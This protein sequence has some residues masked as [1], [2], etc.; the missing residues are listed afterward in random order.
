[1]QV[2]LTV[3]DCFNDAF[4]GRQADSLAARGLDDIE[5]SFNNVEQDT[6]APT[7]WQVWFSC[8]LDN[9]MPSNPEADNTAAI[10]NPLLRDPS[11]LYEINLRLTDDRE[12]QSLNAQYRQQDRPTDVLAFAAAEANVPQVEALPQVGEA[13]FSDE[14]GRRSHPSPI[15]LCLGDIVISVET[16]QRQ[17]RSQNH[18]LQTELAWLACHGLLHLLGWD[19]P[20]NATLAQMLDRQVALLQTIGLSFQ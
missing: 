19:H 15:P 2:D 20:D 4:Q 1:M 7:T 17:A 10:P 3:Q 11:R 13:Q 14:A 16:A 18:P 12:I 5:S 9:L 8:W 6:I